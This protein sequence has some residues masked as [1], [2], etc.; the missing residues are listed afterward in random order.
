MRRSL[1]VL[2]LALSLPAVQAS[3]HAVIIDSTPAPYAHVKPGPLAMTLRYNS[4]IDVGRSKLQLAHGSDTQR[5]TLTD[6]AAPDL[7]QASA[8][9]QP[10]DY[11]I[12][13]QVLAVDG[14]VTRGRIPFTVD[15]SS[16]AAAK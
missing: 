15:P 13:W 1:P 9:V 10:G 16:Q 6:A 3:A 14:H 2:T 8:T 7:L 5:L 11:E 4:R 12:R